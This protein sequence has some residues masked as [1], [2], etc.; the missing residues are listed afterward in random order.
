MESSYEYNDE[1]Y[2]FNE[3][4]RPIGVFDSMDDAVK[5]CQEKEVDFWLNNNP[6][7]FCYSEDEILSHEYENLFPGIKLEDLYITKENVSSFIDCVQLKP[8]YILPCK[9]Y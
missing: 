6:S 8:F 1:I 2:Y 9:Q 4:G 5:L 3:G 7:D